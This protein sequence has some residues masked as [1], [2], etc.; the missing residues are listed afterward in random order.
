MLAVFLSSCVLT[1][2]VGGFDVSGKVVNEITNE[3]I[4]GAKVFL[5]YSAISFW[6]DHYINALLTLASS[7]QD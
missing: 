5:N 4:E 2:S 3:P 6:G 7:R 1:K